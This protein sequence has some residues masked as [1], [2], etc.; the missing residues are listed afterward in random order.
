[1][2]DLL[3]ELRRHQQDY[4]S[5]VHGPLC[6]EAADQIEALV[7][8]LTEL[9]QSFEFYVG[10]ATPVAVEARRILDAVSTPPGSGK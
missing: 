1:M 6:G 9:Y 4:P 2:T 7:F 8:A 10:K 5:L 3:T